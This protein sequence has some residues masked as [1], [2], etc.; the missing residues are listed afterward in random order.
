MTAHSAIFKALSDDTRARLLRVLSAGTFH[1]NELAEILELGQSTISRHLRL[2]LDANLVTCRRSRTWAYYSLPTADGKVFPARILELLTGEWKE[3]PNPDQAGIE[4]ALAKRRRTTSDFFRRSAG[5]WDRLRDEALGPP[6]HLDRL[7]EI[8][9]ERASTVVDLGTGTGVLLE[10]LADRAGRLI[11]I[12]SSPEMLEIARRRAREANIA[13]AQLRLGALEHLPLGN[14]EADVMIAN[15]VLHHVADVSEVLG[16]IQ[17]GLAP[18]GRLLVV[19]LTEGGDASFWESIGAMWPGFRPDDLHA[20]IES[21]GFRA[22]RTEDLG[23]PTQTHGA[24]NGN[25]NG[26]PPGIFLLEAV[27]ID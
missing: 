22:I 17:R 8:L 12:D 1:V 21:A 25:S 27:R 24:T 3:S 11:G 6:A 26:E 14:G 5:H 13:N 9:G 4:S 10:K 23:A 18:G 19:E 16:E 2:L 20:K 7:L 15:L